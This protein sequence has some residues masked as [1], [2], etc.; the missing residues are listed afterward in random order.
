M[1]SKI[2]LNKGWSVRENSHEDKVSEKNK[3]SAK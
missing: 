2:A 1:R 3:L